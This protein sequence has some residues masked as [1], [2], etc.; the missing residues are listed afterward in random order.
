MWVVRRYVLLMRKLHYLSRACDV[1]QYATNLHEFLYDFC[2]HY[3]EYCKVMDVSPDSHAV[4][5]DTLEAILLFMHPIT[6]FITEELWR[7]L[8]HE[9]SILDNIYPDDMY[10]LTDSIAKTTMDSM[11]DDFENTIKILSVHRRR[12]EESSKVTVNDNSVSYGDT[13]VTD[14]NNVKYL[15]GLIKG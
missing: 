7:Q 5:K 15:T 12:D 11:A 13:I 10:F 14:A 2:C 9:T 6:P 8:G 4:F 3:L 1:A